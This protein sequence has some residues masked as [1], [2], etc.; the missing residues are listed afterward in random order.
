MLNL[1]TIFS[2]VLTVLA[3]AT[4][5]THL[6]LMAYIIIKQRFYEKNEQFLLGYLVIGGLWNFLVLVEDSQQL[7]DWLGLTFLSL[8][9]LIPLAVIIWLLAQNFLKKETTPVWSLAVGVAGLILMIGFDSETLS[10]SELAKISNLPLANNQSV[11]FWLGIVTSSSLMGHALWQGIRTRRSMYSPAHRNQVMFLLLSLGWISLG[12]GLYLTLRPLAQQL[13]LVIQCLGSGI[14]TFTVLNRDLP[15]IQTSFKEVAQVSGLFIFNLLVYSFLVYVINRAWQENNQ[16]NATLIALSTGLV[17][18]MLYGPLHHQVKKFLD[19]RLFRNQYDYQ[20]VVQSYLKAINNVLDVRALVNILLTFVKNE[21]DV[22]TGS[23]LILR[24]ES[25]N[26]YHFDILFDNSERKNGVSLRK[27]SPLMNQLAKEGVSITQ[28]IINVTPEFYN[29]DPQGIDK[30]RQLSAERFF[31][32]RRHNKL[33]A[34][35]ALGPFTTGEPYSMEHVD[36]LSTL[37]D[38]TAIALDNARLFENARVQVEEITRTNNFTDNV[39]ASISSGVITADTR[40][41]ITILNHAA[42]DILNLPPSVKVGDDLNHVMAYLTG[43]PLPKLVRDVKATQRSYRHHHVNIDLPDGD[44]LNLNLDLVPIKNQDGRLRGVAIVI[45]DITENRRLRAVHDMFRRYV[46]PAVVDRLPNDPSQLKL[47]GHRQEVSI[48]F[49]DIRGF[50]TFSEYEEPE[51]L[52]NIL[53]NY[54]N[55]AAQSILLYEGTL[56]KFMGDAVM[57]IFNAPLKQEDHVLRAVK[58]ANAMQKAI[59]DFHRQQGEQT[60]NL[61]F[62]VGI[63]VGE[64]VVGNVG[65]TKRMDYTTIGDAVNLSKRI[66]ENTPGGKILLS[67]STYERV[68]HQVE[69]QPYERLTVKGRERPEQTYELLS[70]LDELDKPPH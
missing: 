30:L 28:Y 14:L 42:I 62:G 23:V 26:E 38:Q 59:T 11:A 21:L 60:S 32:I 29:E 12:L 58:A 46:S 51:N 70:I 66:Q 63:H 64:A 3:L 19:Q 53:N 1:S 68:R 43:T 36:L 41:K 48:L 9:L 67:Q 57:A 44:S 55:L 18:A 56:D 34:I 61:A 24:H 4:T 37:A 52:I 50:S 10:L 20:G 54:L 33:I 31:P 17:L 7:A 35:L 13:G 5:L 45:N 65:T 25:K 40:N 47:G 16:T 49:A 2:S 8:Y 69:A 27:T 39:F 6:G 22:T 15:H